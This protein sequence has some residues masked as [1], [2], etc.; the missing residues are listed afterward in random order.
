MY[1]YIYTHVHVYIYTCTCIYIY[2]CT[3]TYI[4]HSDLNTDYICCIKRAGSLGSP[5]WTVRLNAYTVHVV[6]DRIMQL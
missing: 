2:T 3:C 6:P 1:M 5:D 4:Y